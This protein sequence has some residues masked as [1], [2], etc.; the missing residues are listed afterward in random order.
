MKTFRDTTIERIRELRLQRG[1]TQQGLADRL[2]H[3][4]AHTDRTA[5]AKVENGTRELSLVE[6]FQYA[7]ALHVAPVHL[8]VPTDSDEPI[9]IGPDLLASPYEVR[10]WIRAEPAARPAGS[11]PLL[12]SG[13]ETEFTA[14]N[15][16]LAE[17]LKH[18]PLIVSTQEQEPDD[19]ERN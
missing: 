11:A 12:D 3:L 15:G 7:Q 19:E 6:A 18:A 8:F 17:W 4:G 5:V 1:M 10:A 2:N 16:A 14:A 13:P 9:Q